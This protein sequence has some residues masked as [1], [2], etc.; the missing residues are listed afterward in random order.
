MTGVRRRRRSE[1]DSETAD[2]SV[3][4]TSILEKTRTPENSIGEK[5]AAEKSTALLCTCGGVA[6]GLFF[7]FLGVTTEVSPSDIAHAIV[8]DAGS[9]GTRA[10]LFSFQK[11]ILINTKMVSNNNRI[12]GLGYGAPAGDFFKPLLDDV[13]AAVPGT[14][15]R[16][17]VPLAL[18]A[19]AGLRQSG[20]EVAEAALAE[21]RKVLN[22]SGFLVKKEWVSILDEQAEATGAW[23]SVNYLLGH[24]NGSVAKSS[25]VV[26]LGG[27]S[28]QIVFEATDDAVRV[29]NEAR[30]QAGNPRAGQSLLPRLAYGEW[31]GQERK[32]VTYNKPGFGLVDFL[33]KLYLLFDQ[34]GVLEEQNPCFRKGKYL[35]KKLVHMGL[36]GTEEVREL[37]LTGD[38]NFERCVASAEIVFMQHGELDKNVLAQMRGEIVAFA[39]VY[40]LTVK[41]GLNE[42]PTL[43]ELR[44]LGE[45][46]CEGNGSIGN[47]RDELCAEYSYV[48]L[49]LRD[50]TGSSSEDCNL[51]IVQYVD[52][53]CLGWALGDALMNFQEELI[54]Q[55][56]K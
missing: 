53:H 3:T 27:A 24:L 32:L 2:E 35:E 40:D 39:Y 7:L 10:Q 51:R 18:R 21:A 36:P 44:E 49:L 19:T 26:E 20:V 47:D 5:V 6:I 50:I 48:Y 4:S 11:G 22:T 25:S 38:G 45:Q 33:K 30:M 56:H 42:Q 29:V 46:L 12:V 28:L 15:R 14:K 41:L 17:S 52:G 23:T 1:T 43:T 54:A 16:R 55:L 34:E 8:F 13:R 9:T 31:G 37:T